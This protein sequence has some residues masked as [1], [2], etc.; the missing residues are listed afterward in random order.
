MKKSPVLFFCL[1]LIILAL[2]QATKYYIKTHIGPFDPLRILP[3]FDIVY[4]ENTGSAFG[5]FKFLGSSF[6]IVVSVVAII[7]LSVLVIK[8]MRNRI[9]YSLLLGGAAGN[10]LDRLFYGHV[11]D[12][13]DVY[14]GRY[15]WPA[16]NVAD[17]ALTI[18]IALLFFKAVFG[19]RNH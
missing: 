7:V 3:F 9:A 5:M 12:F 16:F 15:H 6:F 19:I 1:S 2:D 17:S 14:V 8:D 18:G 11:I 4:V 13:L 10:L